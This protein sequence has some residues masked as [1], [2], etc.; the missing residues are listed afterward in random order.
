MRTLRLNFDRQLLPNSILIRYNINRESDRK[1]ILEP[2]KPTG[3]ATADLCAGCHAGSNPTFGEQAHMTWP[4]NL[5]PSKFPHTPLTNFSPFGEW[6][7]SM[8]G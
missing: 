5:P 1:V 8:T 4:Q 6:G 7:A 3:F 2:P